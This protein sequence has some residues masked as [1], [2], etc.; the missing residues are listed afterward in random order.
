ML[1]WIDK[2]ERLPTQEDGNALGYVYVINEGFVEF[3]SL[4]T[5][6]FGCIT[7]WLPF[8]EMPIPKKWRTPTIHDLAKAGKPIPCR[9][10]DDVADAWVEAFLSAIDLDKT[11]HCGFLCSGNWWRCCEICDD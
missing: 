2:N 6:N 1:S 9:V 8:G 11:K 5:L 4:R 10:R 7:H 3:R